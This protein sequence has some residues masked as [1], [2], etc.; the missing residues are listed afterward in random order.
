[1]LSVLQFF[2]F[3]CN[4]E[5]R[6]KGEIKNLMN[7]KIL[8]P[9]GYESIPKRDSVIIDSMLNKD[10]KI[11]SYV[12]DLPCTSCGI[13]MMSIWMSRID[14]L[15]SNAEYILVVNVAENEK[16]KFFDMMDSV[17]LSHPIMYYDTDTFGVVNELSELLAINKTFLLNK[18]NRIV[19]VGEPFKNEKLFDLYKRTIMD[20]SQ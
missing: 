1:M 11:V 10:I 17:Q 7:R 3:S 9:M 13:K 15:N 14:S 18:H 6:V 19:L 16:A 5:D 12:D 2:L 4:N 8:F 20:L